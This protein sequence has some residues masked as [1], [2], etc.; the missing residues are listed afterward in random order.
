MQPQGV[1]QVPPSTITEGPTCVLPFCRPQSHEVCLE[2]QVTKTRADPREETPSPS[3]G[4]RPSESQ[5]EAQWAYLSKGFPAN[6]P[7]M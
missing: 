4:S 7:E 3:Q 2:R 6:T 1:D 5:A